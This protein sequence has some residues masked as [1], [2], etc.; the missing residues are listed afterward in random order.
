MKQLY[1][2]VLAGLLLIASCKKDDTQP[3]NNGN[4]NNNTTP[5]TPKELLIGT[6]LINSQVYKNG[7]EQQLDDCAKDN[8]M[9]IKAD[10]T[11]VIDQGAIK[12]D[13]SSAQSTDGNWTMDS[14]PAIYFKL[15]DPNTEGTNAKITQLDETILKLLE[16][17]GE[18]SEVTITFKR[19]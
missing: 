4:N 16:Y 6:W 10:G 13:P 5:K 19:K 18:S 11:Y 3:N 8:T 15:N 12:C 7:G 1:L 9:T 17:E 14:Y 2:C